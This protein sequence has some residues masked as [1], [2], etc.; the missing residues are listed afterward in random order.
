MMHHR[1]AVR[2]PGGRVTPIHIKWPRAPARRADRHDRFFFP[3]VPNLLGLLR[4]RS[5]VIGNP[6]GHSLSPLIH[7]RFAEQTG[8]AIEYGRLLVPEGAFAEHARAFFAGGGRGANVTLP[9]KVDAFE[10]ADVASE[11]SRVAGAVNFLM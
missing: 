11:R 9:F 1:G 3:G 10:F 4:D 8:D 2:Q 7:A 6:V 5:V